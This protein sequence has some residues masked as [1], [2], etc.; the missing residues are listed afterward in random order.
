MSEQSVKIF[1]ELI[2]LSDLKIKKAEREKG[3]VEEIVDADMACLFLEEGLTDKEAIERFRNE[4]RD[5]LIKM[6]TYVI[7][8]AISELENQ[9]DRYRFYLGLN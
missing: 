4:H 9:R 2:G 3:R 1:I 6:R 7:D 8:S 5:S